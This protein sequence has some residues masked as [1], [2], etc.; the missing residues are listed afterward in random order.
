MESNGGGSVTEIGGLNIMTW[1]INGL[2]SFQNFPEIVRNLKADIICFQETKVTRDMLPE[3]SAI[4]PGYTSYYT[5]TRNGTAY[6]GVA[7]YVK[8][9]CT[10]V[11]AEDGLT[12]YLSKEG[13]EIGGTHLINQEFTQDE[14]K[15]LDS[16]GRC[17]ITKHKLN[18]EENK[19]D[20]KNKHLVLIN[21]YCPRADP[22]REDRKEF[23]LKFY[24]ALDIRANTL[25]EEGNHVIVLG[26]VNTSHRE[27]DH[28][29]P[30]DEFYDHPGRRFLNHF[31]HVDNESSSQ[32]CKDSI[33]KSCETSIP[34]G[35]QCER[36]NIKQNQFHDAFRIIHGSRSQAFTCWNTKM[37]CRSTNYGTRIDYIFISHQMK[38]FLKDC[39]IHAEILG[40]D[41]CPVSANFNFNITPGQK[42]PPLATKFYPEFQGRQLNLK[43][44]LATSSQKATLPANTATNATKRPLESS[45]IAPPAAK[46]SKQAPAKITNFFTSKKQDV[47]VNVDVVKT[48][49][50]EIVHQEKDVAQTLME[51]VS[52]VRKENKAAWGKLF[53]A[54]K[55]APLCAGHQE[56]CVKRKVNKKG[57]NQGREFYCCA[58]GEGRA[59]D[60]NARCNFFKWA[61]T[62]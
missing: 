62:K 56:E 39:D 11:A 25:A 22:E 16:E 35:W 53:K 48:T 43:D 29:D 42:P 58:R 52:L 12:G 23:K 61:V 17:V 50:E 32:E 33:Q 49:T 2:R 54:P 7:T 18:I 24:K 3:P 37:N 5:F 21:V 60:P 31:L 34:D 27:L 19:Q 30:Y 26:D 38:Q 14:L 51:E 6:S 44:M 47:N 46:K 10:P 8:N 36:V 13:C 15:S 55:P 4:I 9:N 20:K 1:N 45:S 57:P 28:C 41:H 40:S 59:D